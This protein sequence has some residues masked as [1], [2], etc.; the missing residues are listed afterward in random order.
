MYT[1]SFI[2]H[3][4]GDDIYKDIAEDIETSFHTSNCELDEPLVKGKDKKVIGL[5]KDELGGEVMK[6]FIKLRVKTKKTTMMK[7]K[8]EKEQQSL[9]W[10]T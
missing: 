4:K 7:I 8:K 3:V 9:P 2:V 6:E 10:K 5:I 1:D